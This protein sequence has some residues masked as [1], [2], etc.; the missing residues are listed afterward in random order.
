M[1][2]VVIF[3]VSGCLGAMTMWALEFYGHFHDFIVILCALFVITPYHTLW[4]TSE[5]L[6]AQS[7]VNGE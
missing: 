7:A 4:I 2:A 3:P 1:F 5:K 6:S